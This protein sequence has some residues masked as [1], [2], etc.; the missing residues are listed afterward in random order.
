MLKLEP[1]AIPAD[2]RWRMRCGHLTYAGFIPHEQLIGHAGIITSTKL[3]GWSVVHELG[4]DDYEHTHFGFIFDRPLD[5]VGARKF[6]VMIAATGTIVHPNMQPKVTMTSCEVLFNE[7]HLGR[8]Y[9]ITLGKKTYKKPAGGPWQKLPPVFE[10]S[11]EVMKEIT[12]A[13]TLQEAVVV[14][15]VRPRSV[16]DVKLLRSDSDRAPKKFKH[17]FPKDTFRLGLLPRSWSVLH[18]HGASGL[19][20]TKAACALFDNPLIIKPFNAVGCVE[21]LANFVPSVHDGIIFDEVDLRAFSR[22][23]AIALVDFDEESVISVRYTSIS[24][25]AGVKKI[26]VSN[27]ADVWPA[28]DKSIGAIARRVISFHATSKLFK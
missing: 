16:M 15:G 23:Q 26:F 11:R 28:S 21:K 19:G 5:L 24:M 2:F 3:I 1:I 17:L 10:W 4:E 20:K 25:P 8:K 27:E 14:A 12:E 13:P 18:I 22:E 6:D 9:D 7:Y